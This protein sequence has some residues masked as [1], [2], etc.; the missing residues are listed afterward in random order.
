MQK[1]ILITI[2]ILAAVLLLSSVYIVD[3]TQQIVVLRFGEP[4]RQEQTPGLKFK[5]PF[6]DNVQYFDKRLLE[7]NADPKEVI[8]SDQKRLIV[9]AFAKYKITNPL[10]FFQTVRNEYNLRSRMNSIL[11]S[12]LRQVIGGIPLHAL[13]QEGRR[14]SIMSRIKDIV[15]EEVNTFGV[16]VVDVR[17][18]RADLPDENSNAI[19]RRMQ[20]E[21]EREAKELRAEGVEESQKIKSR[22]EKDR[23]VILA[24]AKKQSEIAR[25]QGERLST[26][27]FANAFGVDPEF[28]SFYRSMN[29][30]ESSIANKDKKLVIAPQ[31]EFFKYFSNMNGR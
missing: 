13:L 4:V 17:I 23:V 9:D 29:A 30:Y 15:K 1:K 14:T 11:D 28:Y 7:L 31:G 18:M 10:K 27:I 8:A 25:G 19:Y 2:A 12:S 16:E 21:R 22:A 26:K 20:T 3:Q 6:V 24:E 5:M